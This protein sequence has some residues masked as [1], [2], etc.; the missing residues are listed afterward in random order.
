MAVTKVASGT[1]AA[2]IATEHTLTTQTTANVYVLELSLNNMT[3][4]DETT[5]RLLTQRSTGS[6]V[7]QLAYIAHFGPLA[8]ELVKTYS[9][10]VPVDL[11]I[12]ATLEQTTGSTGISYDWKLLGLQ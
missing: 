9:L 1:Q 5:L 3:A 6:T 11:R 12:R 4:G 10:P 2:T 8:P 7:L